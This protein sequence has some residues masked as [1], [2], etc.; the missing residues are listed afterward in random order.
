MCRPQI[1]ERREAHLVAL[2]NTTQVCRIRLRRLRLPQ[3]AKTGQPGGGRSNKSTACE[4]RHEKRSS[5]LPRL[6]GC[7]RPGFALGA[8]V[9]GKLR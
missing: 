9:P 2:E 4:W 5:K 8:I 7:R 1:V 6:T 3:K